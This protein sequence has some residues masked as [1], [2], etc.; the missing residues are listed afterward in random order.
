MVWVCGVEDRDV[1]NC[2]VVSGKEGVLVSMFVG[3]F[4]YSGWFYFFVL[5]GMFVLDLLDVKVIFMCNDF[6]YYLIC[7]CNL[8]CQDV[9]EGVLDMLVCV[10]LVKVVEVGKLLFCYF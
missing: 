7:C 3:G 2:V 4:G 5:E 8:M 9:Y 10:V 1:C 6:G